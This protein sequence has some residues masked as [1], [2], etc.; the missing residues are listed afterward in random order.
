MEM[1]KPEQDSKKHLHKG[2]RAR[3][4]EEF[5]QNG[6][7]HFPDHKMLELLLFYVIPREDT[8]PIG[9]RLL[10]RFDSLSGAFDA[11]MEL[12]TKVEGVGQETATL[13]KLIPALCQAY[14]DDKVDH[15]HR[16]HG[17][18]EAKE[19]VR[20]KF[21]GKDQEMILLVC[22]AANGKIMLCD[23]MAQGTSQQ[24]LLQ[25]AE[26]ARIALRS[27]AVKVLLAHNHPDGFCNPSSQ[28]LRTTSILFEE[29]HRIGVELTDHIIVAPDDVY[30]MVENNMFP[31]YRG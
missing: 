28:D 6:L 12:L 26:I 7:E 15:I 4:R 29:L 25:P 24:V 3:V 14:L 8:N 9:H 21:L 11:P 16:L 10:E 23:W 2:H 31:A 17:Y 19:Y 22:M 1:K 13:I 18:K 27:G 20:Y 5:R 30:S